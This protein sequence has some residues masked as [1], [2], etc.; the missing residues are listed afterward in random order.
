MSDIPGYYAPGAC[1]RLSLNSAEISATIVRIFTPFTTS[2]VLLVRTH[3]VPPGTNVPGEELVIVKVYDPR[4]LFYRNF[5]PSVYRQKLKW[6][7]D[8]EV[9]AAERRLTPWHPAARFEFILLP[10]EEEDGAAEVEDYMFR[11]SECTAWTETEAYRRLFPLQGKGIPLFFGSGR[12]VLED[13]NCPR[14]FN[15]HANILEYIPDAI[16]IRDV[17]ATLITRPLVQS[18]LDTV[19]ALGDLGVTHGDM[20]LGNIL[21]SPKSSP[22]RAVII[23]FGEGTLRD[24][25]FNEK[26]WR[27]V[28]HEGADNT[29]LKKR[30][31]AALG[32]QDLAEWISC[33]SEPAMPYPAGTR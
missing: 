31:T 27:K 19:Q 25:R 4:F 30:L 32:V 13:P 20:N 1:I 9:I 23:D 28:V 5:K 26:E 7:Y 10:I 8:G 24:E 33:S 22:P 6:S 15:P 16:T 11:T 18:L 21:F 14:T 29:Y 2:Q 3:Y 17:P 12:L